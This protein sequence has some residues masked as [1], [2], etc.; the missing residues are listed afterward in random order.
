[1]RQLSMILTTLAV[2]S[3]IQIDD[4][5]ACKLLSRSS[6]RCCVSRCCQPNACL[7][8][9][10]GP[11]REVDNQAIEAVEQ[12]LA[13]PAGDVSAVTVPEAPP[14]PQPIETTAVEE[15]PREQPPEEPA[16]VPEEPGPAAD[17][18]APKPD[19][20]EEAEKPAGDEATMTE[21]E[22]MKAFFGEGAEE[23]DATKESPTPA[24]EPEAPKPAP[25]SPAEG[26][27]KS[28]L[29]DFFSTHSRKRSPSDALAGSTGF[30]TW[31]D[32][33]GKYQIEAKF[34]T[35]FDDGTVR[36]EKPN[37][38]W[39][40]LPYTQLSQAD[41]LMARQMFDAGKMIAMI[42]R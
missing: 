7:P 24:E 6:S 41:Q 23:P 27:E 32:I 38:R 31:R 40:R 11:V 26:G 15:A 35:C 34:V 2:T 20:S 39:V 21:E 12:P 36:L 28:A 29:D 9:V 10:C 13:E 33:S 3:V 1:M 37:G 42:S 17:E 4:V 18:A 8:T 30:R 19:S 16:S 22:R 5:P 14:A 25:E